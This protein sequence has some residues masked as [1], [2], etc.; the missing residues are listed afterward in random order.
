MMIQLY[1]RVRAYADGALVQ[2][3]I[4]NLPM[5]MV[6]QIQAVASSRR[7]CLPYGMGLIYIFRK[8]G[9]SLKDKAFKELLHSDRSDDRSLHCMEYQKISG[10]WVRRVSG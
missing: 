10:W 2:G 4:V 9:V 5:I 1:Y 8:Y 3:T 7:L 6:R